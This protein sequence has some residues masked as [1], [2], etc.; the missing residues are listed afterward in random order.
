LGERFAQIIVVL[1]DIDRPT[2]SLM[3]EFSA[4]P[5]EQSHPALR[6]NYY[7]CGD[8]RVDLPAHDKKLRITKGEGSGLHEQ[9]PID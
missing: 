4:E 9:L 6:L 5:P 8:S 7:G 3:R 1:S 2:L